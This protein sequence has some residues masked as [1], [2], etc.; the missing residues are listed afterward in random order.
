MLE[1]F[2]L[3]ANL[4]SEQFARLESI[5][6]EISAKKGEILFSPGDAARGFYAVLEGA[7]RIYR[8]SPKG[9]EITL[10]IAES[11]DIFASA[12]LYSD[13]YHCFAET[14][15]ESR[16][17]L[18]RKVAFLEMIQ[19]DIRFAGEWIRV[20]SRQVMHLH[21]RLGELTLKTPKARIAGYLLLLCEMQEGDRATL[22]VHRKSIATLLGMTHETFY[23]SAKELE[24]EGMVRFDGQGIE[25]LNRCH[26]EELTE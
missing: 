12:S 25:V 14:L 2:P 18:V 23:R 22:P 19:T 4:P 5:A 16:V 11:G 20:L 26:L 7:V 9:K 21:R 1:K 6:Q 10:E 3:F 24:N 8:I 17:C 13:V 15:K